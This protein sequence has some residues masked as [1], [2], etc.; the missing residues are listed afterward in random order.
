M[1]IRDEASS[2]ILNNQFEKALR[3]LLQVLEDAKSDKLE[4]KIAADLLVDRLHD[5]VS[6]K[7]FQNTWSIIGNLWF[8]ENEYDKAIITFEKLDERGMLDG[9]QRKN[10]ILSHLRNGNLSSSS[11]LLNDYLNN[12][13]LKKNS[14]KI[15]QILAQL[16]TENIDMKSFDHY[17]KMAKIF[18]GEEVDL[19]SASRER[20]KLLDAL[21][22]V[23]EPE[24][25]KIKNDIFIKKFFEPGIDLE[26]KKLISKIFESYLLGSPFEEHIPTLIQYVLIV[27][28][29]ELAYLVLRRSS[30]I[31]PIKMKFKKELELISKNLD[32]YLPF[33]FNME[34]MDLGEDLFSSEFPAA[35]RRDVKIER[36]K[37]QYEIL[38]ENGYYDQAQGILKQLDM[39]DP[40]H[41][42]ERDQKENK[43]D[44]SRVSSSRH[45]KIKK[46]AQLVDE[47][48]LVTSVYGGK[49]NESDDFDHQARVFKKHIQSMGD[50]ELRLSGK[51]IL[52]SVLSM[53]LYAVAIDLIKE[54]GELF[55][56]D[57]VES[58]YFQSICYFR[59]NMFTLAI[60]K[61]D[62]AL[63]LEMNSVQRCGVLYQKAEMLSLMGRL[64]EALLVYRQILLIDPRHKKANMRALQVV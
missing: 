29:R 8:E 3:I 56:N 20:V 1:S 14:F 4:K 47:V 61:L 2:L 53:E 39:I 49:Q 19:S 36:L 34:E 55:M 11:G 15:L 35:N 5:A 62:E 10:Y 30:E 13:V 44:S 26:R 28:R 16:S 45:E 31:E 7:Q 42:V 25:K 63:L 59:M 32:K 50:Q 33:K 51:D 27:K 18:R 48:E 40:D 57:E 12:L 37:N 60:E 64:K 52:I 17:I 43:S 6:E 58:F 38:L 21:G 23:K 54:R 41:N 46:L 9:S 22:R 24:S